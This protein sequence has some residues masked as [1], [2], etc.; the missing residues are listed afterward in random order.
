[1]SGLYITYFQII[2]NKSKVPSI[3]VRFEEARIANII[4]AI[5]CL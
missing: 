5:L 3:W 4:F 1:M 2:G